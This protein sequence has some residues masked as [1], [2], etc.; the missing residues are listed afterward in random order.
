MSVSDFNSLPCWDPLVFPS[1]TIIDVSVI[2]EVFTIY[3]SSSAR[4]KLVVVV[5]AV[6]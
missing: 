1:L 5:V 3:I 2:N 6:S 4:S